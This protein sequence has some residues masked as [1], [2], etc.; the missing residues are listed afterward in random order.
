MF[1]SSITPKN[2]QPES[3][4]ILVSVSLCIMSVSYILGTES[5]MIQTGHLYHNCS[6]RMISHIMLPQMYD[7]SMKY[8][9]FLVRPDTDW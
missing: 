6:D 2:H 7:T 1:M 8:Y 9:L 3:S 5:G 4:M